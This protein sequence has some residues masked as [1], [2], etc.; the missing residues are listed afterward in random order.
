MTALPIQ[1]AAEIAVGRV[2]NSLPAGFLVAVFAWIVLRSLPRQNSGTRFAVWFAAL[3]AVAGL[4]FIGILDGGSSFSLNGSSGPG[5]LSAPI[6]LPA[7]WALILFM[8]WLVIAVAAMTSLAFGMWRLRAMR[9]D[10]TV[11]D[12]ATLHPAVQK[13]IHD[14]APPRSVMIATS[15]SVRVPAA[16]GFWKPMIVIPDWA[17]RE[18]PPEELNAIL[19]HEHAH[20]ERWDDWSNL[21]QKAVRAVFFFHP[22][23]WWIEKQLSVEREMACDDAVLAHTGNPRGYAACLVSL[24]EKSLAHRGWAMAQAAV[25][26]AQEAS[27]RLAQILDSKRPAT[28]RLGKPALALVG[29]FAM[30]CLVLSPHA[31]EVIAF[32]QPAANAINASASAPRVSVD[33][34]STA[35][36]PA[37]PEKVPAAAK[38][39]TVTFAAKRRAPD[40]RPIFARLPGRVAASHVVPVKAT[41]K[42]HATPA[43][44]MLIFVQT[45]ETVG[46][47]AWVRRVQIW[48]LTIISPAQIKSA[49]EVTAHST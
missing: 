2:L 43:P 1:A 19:L 38:V 48:R 36:V 26:R 20:L 8:G 11:I 39:R 44:E 33:P 28:T 4:P 23:M 21:V 49:T 18:L 9:K 45:T 37:A 12:V 7:N 25:H 41:Q 13:T 46:P 34:S 16:I 40:A 17:L 5:I 22:A 47:N 42:P 35:V 30:V 31:P 24:L 15:E 14:F 3:L 10:C 29:G 6:T 27:K 32:T